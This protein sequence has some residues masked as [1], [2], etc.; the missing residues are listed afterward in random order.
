[1]GDV[2]EGAAEREKLR[3]FFL[4]RGLGYFKVVGG[5]TE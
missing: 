2:P 5:G 1:L 4:L 3:F